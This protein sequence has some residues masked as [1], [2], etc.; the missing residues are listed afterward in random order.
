L[1]HRGVAQVLAKMVL[2]S[3]VVYGA[4]SSIPANKNGKLI[5]YEAMKGDFVFN[6]QGQDHGIGL[7]GCVT[8][9]LTL[10]LKLC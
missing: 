3:T 1:L 6:Y 8:L 2:Y 5:S 9:T 4:M 7:I 10:M